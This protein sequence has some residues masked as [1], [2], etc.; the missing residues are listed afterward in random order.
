VNPKTVSDL[1]EEAR[2]AL[3][4]WAAALVA[5]AAGPGP[6]AP[7]QRAAWRLAQR[8]YELAAAKLAEAVLGTDVD[9]EIQRHFGD[10]WGDVAH[11]FPVR[12]ACLERVVPPNK[13]T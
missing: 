5:E 12:R 13:S 1:T 2:A 3:L 10:R 8:R 9:A 6:A 11:K 4:E 7:Q